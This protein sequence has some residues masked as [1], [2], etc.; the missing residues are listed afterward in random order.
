MARILAVSPHLDDAVL[1]Y[2]GQLAMLAGAGDQVIAY[3]LFAGTPSPPYSPGAAAYHAMWELTGDPVA[4]RRVEDHRALSVLG[5]TPVHGGFL[6]AI[7]RRDERGAWL[8]Q[9]GLPT[10]HQ[11]EEPGLLAEI[12]DTLAEFIREQR[13]DRIVTCAAIGAHVDHRRARD[14]TMVAAARTSV[15]LTLWTDFP[16]ITWEADVLPPLPSNVAVADPVAEP[17]T[18]AALDAWARACRC[19]AS[20]LSMLEEDGPLPDQLA[21]YCAENA[22]RFGVQGVYEV[23]R[24]VKP[25]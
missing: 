4:P 24:Q 19:Y 21:A 16:Y 18:P 22:S 11:G 5:V 6:D 7:Y 20:Q 1:S 12:A 9:E 25:R 10:E 17:L 2:G 3:T 14:A 15:P 23:V 8:V 13:P